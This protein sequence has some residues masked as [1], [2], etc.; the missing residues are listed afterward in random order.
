MNATS[1][2]TEYV[3]LIRE[4]RNFRYLWFGQVISLLGDWFNLIASATLIANITKSGL[5]VGG[6]FVVRMLAPFLIHPVAGVMADRYNRR[7][8]LI[9]TDLSRALIVLGFLL[10]RNP[11]Q[12]WLIYALTALQLGVSGIFFPTRSA[13]LPDVVPNEGLALLMHFLPL[14]GR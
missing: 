2:F 10:I 11:G 9:Y 5:A 7:N 4:N 13:I 1:S 8:L 14:H 12:V 6:L 3:D